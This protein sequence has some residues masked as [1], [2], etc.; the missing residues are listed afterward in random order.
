MKRSIKSL[1]YFILSSQSLQLYRELVKTVHKIPDE[2][3]QR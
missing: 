1:K 2:G 3:S